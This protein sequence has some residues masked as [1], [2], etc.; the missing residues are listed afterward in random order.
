[1]K[2]QQKIFE[3]FPRDPGVLSSMLFHPRGCDALV[4]QWPNVH[5]G[6]TFVSTR[7]SAA[8]CMWPTLKVICHNY[9]TLGPELRGWC[10]RVDEEMRGRRSPLLLS[11]WL[12]VYDGSWTLIPL[13][14]PRLLRGRSFRKIFTTGG[15]SYARRCCVFSRR[16]SSLAET[17]RS[18]ASSTFILELFDYA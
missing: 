13:E 18:R 14:D 1:M 9:I 5:C 17:A 8:A 12:F 7:P 4:V 2:I 11:S 16:I 15:L 3:T 6:R 10:H